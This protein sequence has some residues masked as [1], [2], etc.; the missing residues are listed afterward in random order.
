M[1]ALRD[2]DDD[3]WRRFQR[4]YAAL[5]LDGFVGIHDSALVRVESGARTIDGLGAYTERT[6]AG[7]ARASRDGD[8]LS[9]DFRFTDRIADEDMAC[10]RGVY[11]VVI[12]GADRSEQTFYG[13]F[14]TILRRSDAGWRIALDHDEELSRDGAAA[15]DVAAGIGD[16]APFI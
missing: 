7:F 13:R 6:A 8:A 15:F 1:S 10:D 5:D 4:A 2:I 11:R 16:H 3:V 9:I 14:H 12:T